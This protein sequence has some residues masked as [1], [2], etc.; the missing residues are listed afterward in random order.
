MASDYLANNLYSRPRKQLCVG[1]ARHWHIFHPD[2][3]ITKDRL[4]H[5]W[6]PG[7]WR[8]PD[9]SCPLKPLLLL[10]S[11]LSCVRLCVTPGTAAH[12]APP[13][14]GFS[15]Q[16]RSSP[17][18]HCCQGAMW[19]LDSQTFWLYKCESFSF[20][21]YDLMV[22]DPM[23]YNLPGSSVHG[24]LQT[25]ILEWVAVP[26]S[27]G[28]SWPRNGTQV[29]CIAGRFIT[30]WPTREAWLYKGNRKIQIFER[31]LPCLKF[32]QFKKNF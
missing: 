32:C 22:C 26:F 7:R 3:S 5:S 2:K 30:V 8:W 15:R 28:S 24:I 1:T 6:G 31:N 19:V 9:H 20:L 18:P 16:E 23:D 29:S 17:L 25:R 4:K 13:S 10:L 14:L 12:Q 21:L 27:R 11:R